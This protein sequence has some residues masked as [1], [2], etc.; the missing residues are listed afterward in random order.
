[1]SD[2]SHPDDIFS[3]KVR[4]AI[5]LALFVS[6]AAALATLLYGARFV[7]PQAGPTDSYGS[8]PLGHRAFAETMEHLG[9][10]VL[11]NRGDRYDRGTAPLLLLEPG[12]EARVE[13]RLRR[14]SDAL[15]SRRASGLPTLVVPPKWTFEVGLVA[16]GAASPVDD[17]AIKSVLAA[18]LPTGELLSIARHE[19]TEGHHR[20]E[21]LLGDFTVEAPELQV[22]PT[23]PASATVL[24]ES[25]LGAVVLAAAD[26]TVIVSDPDLVHNYN[27]HRA[28][29]AAL[30][31]ALIDRMQADTLV[32][33][34]TFHGHGNVL[35]LKEALGQFP[36]ILLV[37]H[38]LMLLLLV[39]AMGGRRFGPPLGEPRRAHGPQEA[40]AVAASVLADGQPIGL[41]AYHYVLETF[42]DLRRRLDLAA[43]PSPDTLAERLDAL[44]HERHLPPGAAKL[45]RRARALDPR[46][47]RVHHEAWA[48]ARSA[49]QLRERMLQSPHRPPRASTHH[50][51]APAAGALQRTP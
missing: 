7:T 46:G 1:M 27:F 3:P 42:E 29:H 51:I 9:I 45:L 48:I 35:S 6:A 11:Q 44:A 49:H 37:A 10:H 26:G 30:W 36:A 4:R 18:A 20:L 17:G 24:L 19:D 25:E 39:F 32:I 34:E 14:L 12:L 38:G 2:D 13:G 16:D 8:G 50:R 43:A 23:P 40:I 47:R 28:D 31:L 21:G 33:D 15:A 22:L 41:L 5:L